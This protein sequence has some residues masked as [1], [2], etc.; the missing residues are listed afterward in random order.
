MRS[1]NVKILPVTSEGRLVGI[2]T[3]DDIFRATSIMP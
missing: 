2:L 1:R 3:S